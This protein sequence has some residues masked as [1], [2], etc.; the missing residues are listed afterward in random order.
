MASPSWATGSASASQLAVTTGRPLD[1][2][3]ERNVYVGVEALPAM[4]RQSVVLD[5]LISAC[6]MLAAEVM[7]TG[8]VEAAGTGT[9]PPSWTPFAALHGTR[10]A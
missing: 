3:F 4:V 10:D 5:P 6:E 7:V 8:A 9:G 2:S 1:A